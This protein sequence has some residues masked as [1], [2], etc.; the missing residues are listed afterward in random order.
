MPTRHCSHIPTTRC[1]L[2]SLPPSQGAWGPRAGQTQCGFVAP[3]PRSTS[4]LG[5]GACGCP[6]MPSSP[7]LLMITTKLGLNQQEPWLSVGSVRLPRAQHL[8][9]PQGAGG[10]EELKS[11]CPSARNFSAKYGDRTSLQDRAGGQSQR[12]GPPLTCVWWG[13]RGCKG[14]PTCLSPTS[15]PTGHPSLLSNF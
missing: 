13:A 6:G 4:P 10:Q 2:A 15:L 8:A 9:E 12:P 5:L 11:N 7:I 14:P 3:Q 1:A